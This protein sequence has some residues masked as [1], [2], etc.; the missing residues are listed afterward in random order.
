MFDLNALMHG[1]PCR[2][3]ALLVDHSTEQ[4]LLRAKQ[5]AYPVGT[6][7]DSPNPSNA[8][9]GRIA[10]LDAGAGDLVAVQQSMKLDAALAAR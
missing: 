4:S 9:R 10:L 7:T 3:I 6:G 1:V 8:G 2:H 5:F